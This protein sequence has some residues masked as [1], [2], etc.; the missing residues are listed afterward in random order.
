MLA[1]VGEFLWTAGGT[2]VG[3]TRATRRR[4]GR[5]FVCCLIIVMKGC[6]LG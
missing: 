2:K 3:S 1:L 4:G 6:S 5:V